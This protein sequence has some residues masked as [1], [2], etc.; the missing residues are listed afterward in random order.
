MESPRNISGGVTPKRALDGSGSVRLAPLVLSLLGTFLFQ[1][2]NM[3]VF[4]YVIGLGE[5]AG[6]P[7][8][9]VS[10]SLAAASW[11]GIAGAGVVILL[12]TR[13][14]RTLPLAVAVILTAAC[15][16]ALHFSAVPAV[17][18]V[19]NCVV[20][21]TWSMGIPYLLGL[22]ASFDA[23]GQMA[24]I[25][26]FASKMGL[27]TGPMIAALVVGQDD[28]GL[29]VNLGTAIIVATLVVAWYPSRLLDGEAGPS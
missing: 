14:G 20:G 25:G 5:H 13:Y 6:L 10:P 11:V 24:A 9:F 3:A 21:A 8:S 19:A 23:S 16:W 12:S 15:T 18:L 27:A 2:G 22:C 1:A 7:M 17:Y 4:A 29:V 28:Y 26:G